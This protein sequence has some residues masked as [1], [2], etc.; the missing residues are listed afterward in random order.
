MLNSR[1]RTTS[2]SST[3]RPSIGNSKPQ[4]SAKKITR[5]KP[6]WDVKIPLKKLNFF[7]NFLSIQV[8]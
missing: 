7:L 6:A 3:N 4:N 8:E 2:A 1:T 5:T